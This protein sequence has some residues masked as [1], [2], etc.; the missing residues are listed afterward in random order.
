[1][2]LQIEIPKEFE[3]D[4]KNEQFKDFFSRVI[5]DIIEHPTIC[6]NYEIET[7]NMFIDVFEN[8]KELGE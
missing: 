1:M 7:A 2:K 8:A 4:F 3:Q 6:G 5:V